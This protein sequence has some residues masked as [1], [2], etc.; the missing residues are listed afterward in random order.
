MF[1]EPS[2]SWGFPEAES[3]VGGGGVPSAVSETLLEQ[4]DKNPS[5]AGL[6]ALG[7]HSKGFGFVGFGSD[8]R[9][10]VSFEGLCV[11]EAQPQRAAF[12]DGSTPIAKNQPP[13]LS[14]FYVMSCHVMSF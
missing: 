3:A 4:E 12:A 11:S 7:S 2:A 8:R 1:P 9:V 14:P 13:P 6:W 5:S 10:G